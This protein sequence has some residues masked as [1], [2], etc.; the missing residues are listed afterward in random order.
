MHSHR[1]TEY[2]ALICIPILMLQKRTIPLE[3][4][5]KQSG[6]IR[7]AHATAQGNDNRVC[8]TQNTY[9]NH[10]HHYHCRCRHVVIVK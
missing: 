5:K 2:M 7:E 9:R 8:C 4:A 3:W 1:H 10:H 6:A